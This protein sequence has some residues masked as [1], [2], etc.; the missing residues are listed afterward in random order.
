MPVE[1]RSIR[2]RTAVGRFP[3]VTLGFGEDP[4]EEKEQPK[5]KDVQTDNACRQW[6][7]KVCPY[8]FRGPSDDDITDTLVTGIDE[9]DKEDGINDEKPV[10]GDSELDGNWHLGELAIVLFITRNKSQP[11]D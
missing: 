1:I 3:T 2:D 4:E 7:L 5:E 11:C 8:C 10:T 9:L 6:L